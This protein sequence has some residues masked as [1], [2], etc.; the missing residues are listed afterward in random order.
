MVL[1]VQEIVSVEKADW[2]TQTREFAEQCD[3]NNAQVQK[4]TH[5]KD[6]Q[7]SVVPKERTQ[8]EFEAPQSTLLRE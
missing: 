3:Q 8:W 5:V 6:V 1:S 4:T 7:V 2:M